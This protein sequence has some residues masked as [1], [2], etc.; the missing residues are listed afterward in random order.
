MS[1]DGMD[2]AA[3][4]VAPDFSEKIEVPKLA[5]Q[6]VFNAL[7]LSMNFG[8]GFLDTEDVQGLREIA[9]ALGVDPNDA[10]P[11]DFR[12]DFPHPFVEINPEDR[13]DPFATKVCKVGEAWRF[14]CRRLESD[15]IH[16]DGA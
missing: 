4:N 15:P 8:S 6:I 2:P 1:D 12:K 13:G 9:T 10:T 14:G 7:C 5:V 11:G 3:L 16:Q